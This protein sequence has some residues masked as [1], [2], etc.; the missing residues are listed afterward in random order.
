MK[1]YTALFL[2]MVAAMVTQAQ[3]KHVL[4]EELT[5]TWCQYCPRGIYF[6]DS[7]ITTYPNVIGIAIHVSDPMEN[8]EYVSECGLLAAP[9]ANIDRGGQGA[10]PPDWF[11]HVADAF[12]NTPKA[13]VEVSTSFNPDSRV[14]TARVKATFFSA[15][16]GNY[17]L[18]AIITE[19]GVTGPAPQYN[20]NNYYS[21]GAPG[22][23]GGFELLPHEIPANMIAHNHVGRTL[24]GGYNGLAG[25][26]PSNVAAGDTVGYTFTSTLPADWDENY[27]RVVGLL[28]TPEN[29]IDNAG[30]SLYLDGNS[31]AAPLFMSAPLTAG[32]E[33][34]PYLL[35]IY[36]SDPDDEDLTLS[37]TGL[38]SWL[39][40][41]AATSVGKI[42]TKATLSGTPTSAGSF[43][44]EIEVSDGLRSSTLSFT[45]EVE[46][47]LPGTWQLVGQQGFA[48]TTNNFGMVADANG[49]LYAFIA[50][51]SN[52]NVYQ[53]TVSGD[54]INYGNLNE[55]A[56]S[57]RI[58]IG[59]DGLTPYVAFS[60]EGPLKV[61]KYVSGAWTQIGNSPASGVQIGFDLDNNDVP[62]VALQDF[63]NNYVGNC[64]K[65]DGSAWIK[66][67]GTAYSGADYGV[68][69]DLKVNKTTG[70]VYVLW[71]NFMGNL[72][73]VS[74]WDGSSWSLTGGSTISNDPVAYSQ[75][76]EIDKYTGDLYVVTASGDGSTGILNAYMFDGTSWTQI[77]SD[78]ADG[79][80]T[81]LETTMNDD[82][83]LLMA[84]VDI[85]NGNSVSAMSYFNGNWEFIGPRGFSMAAASY[86]RITSY[87]N[88][89]YVL[90]KDA[91]ASD[92]ATVRYY[93]FPLVTGV[94]ETSL[95]NEAVN[96]FPN[97]ASHEINIT[98]LKGSTEAS[99]YNMQGAV[100]WKGTVNENQR[101]STASFANGIYLMKTDTKSATFIVQH[102]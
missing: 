35:D 54:W 50:N 34:S 56:S 10:N 89:P 68:W 28:I 87:E 15:A 24:L 19:D 44:V 92:M 59:S 4:V 23:M 99:I 97:P 77:G 6:M 98:G 93:D 70:D 33:G 20:Q 43:P 21:G 39:T 27:I 46:S 32:F 30:K 26:V 96:L 38:P 36:A 91:D 57:G 40:L 11:G 2:M 47:A 82:R 72:A 7:L 74:K 51:G 37:A 52:C 80:V 16:T 45:I 60:K 88:M 64:F 79:Q 66:V 29:T 61:K 101:I 62:Y 69:N 49:T 25:S 71:N 18:A 85:S 3:T 100:I 67:G 41:S 55:T 14:L 42:H 12:A 95:M 73:S 65:Y 86:C 31:N 102:N 22:S 48:A 17:R 76:I 58:R 84:F 8:S 75:N 81:Q 90:Y 9:S 94:A 1:K 53:K 83:I 13:D 78:V 5:G 63:N